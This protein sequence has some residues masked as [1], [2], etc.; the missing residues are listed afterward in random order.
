M[1]ISKSIHRSLLAAALALTVSA[2]ATAPEDPVARRE[3]ERTNDPIESVNRVVFD[4][5]DFLD[6]ILFKPIAQAYRFV[7]PEFLRDRLSGIASNMEEPVIFANNLLQGEFSAGATTLG[8]LVVNSVGGL[9]GM[10]EVAEEVGLERQQ[11]DFGQ[12]LHTWGFSEGPY[13]VLPIFGPSNFRDGVGKVA[14]MMMSPW[15]MIAAE[16]GANN[17]SRSRMELASTVTNGVVKRERNL[18]ALDSLKEG[19]LDFYAQ[20]R[21]VYRQYRNKQLGV[22]EPKATTDEWEDY[23]PMNVPMSHTD[24]T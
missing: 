1:R 13:L 18:E 15:G 21:S 14:D 8:R 17:I 20:M 12:T 24:G 7:F 5:N 11:G 16:A 4:V 10:F 22:A 23:E 9:G 2:C 19:S 3:F 6:R